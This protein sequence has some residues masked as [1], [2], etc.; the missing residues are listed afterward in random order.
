MS[1]LR[2]AVG[3]VLLA[4]A[5]PA[6]PTNF[7]DEEIQAA[8]KSAN[9]K[10]APRSTD[11]QFLRRIY[12][13]LTGR[14]PTPEEARAFL[15]SSSPSKRGD[16]V[17]KL[18]ESE[19]FADRWAQWFAD[20][21]R[22]SH[23]VQRGYTGRNAF[24]NWI[25]N[26]VRSRMPL[27]DL[28]AGI[29]ASQGNNY[30]DAAGAVNF[31]LVQIPSGPP[32]DLADAIFARTASTFLGMGHYDCLLCHDGR[33]HLD[34][35]SLWASRS[36]RLDAWKMSAFFTRVAYQ[37]IGTANNYFDSNIVSDSTS[38]AYRLNTGY[39]NRPARAPVGGA[40]IVPPAYRTGGELPKSENWRREFAQDMVRDP[41]FAR[42]FANRLWLQMMG[43]ALVEPVDALDPDRLDPAKPP[44]SP[45]AL[46]ASHPKLLDKLAARLVEMNFDLRAFL[47][48]IA[49][50]STYQLN[51][52]Y[53]GAWRPEYERL[54]VRH[55]ARRM[56][57]EAIHDA[58]VIATGVLPAYRIRTTAGYLPER[59][60]W[61][62]Q[63]PGPLSGD[64]MEPPE[65][66]FF[67]A[68]FPGDRSLQPRSESGSTRQQLYLMNSPFVNSRLRM[69]SS[70]TLQHAA[71]LKRDEDIA[72]FLF[73][74][75]LSRPPN[76]VELAAAVESLKKSARGKREAIEDLAWA[77]VNKLEFI[78]NP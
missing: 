75:F 23:N 65:A 57:A 9:A 77:C 8:W 52:E 1:S 6:Q 28:A 58:V 33:G 44:P 50:S 48:P 37:R 46:Q 66:E 18:L 63:F 17:D 70:P 61:A 10:P 22:V 24:Y 13:D 27:S 49:L 54:Y 43:T 74:T 45:W 26:A 36:T 31:T 11:A 62:N 69:E 67:D 4:L 19:W 20:L 29:V 12:L 2:L 68:F 72:D 25:R 64:E 5:A 16:V 73:L 14:I 34:A 60:H 15:G 39:G 78:V 55:R 40:A 42:N 21:G 56:E 41:M 7:I 47:R 51:S 53:S 32:Q 30:D 71:A 38:G 3:W 35:L 59:V 76:Q